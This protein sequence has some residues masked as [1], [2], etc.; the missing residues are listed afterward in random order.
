MKEL[1]KPADY[2]D[3]ANYLANDEV[4]EQESRILIDLAFNAYLSREKANGCGCHQCRRA[5]T[6]WLNAFDDE[7]N[8]QNRPP[9]QDHEEEILMQLALKKLDPHLYD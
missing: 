8:R 3:Q 4:L 7:W 2:Q 1:P 9:R 6:R 5:A